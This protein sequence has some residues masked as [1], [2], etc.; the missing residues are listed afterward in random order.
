MQSALGDLASDDK[1]LLTEFF[2]SMRQPASLDPDKEELLNRAMLT[3]AVAAFEA[4]IA[5]IVTAQLHLFPG[6]LDA[7]ERQFS[8]SELEQFE[9]IDDAREAA[10]EARVDTFMRESVE[11]WEKWFDKYA[12]FKV[13]DSALDYDSLREVFERRN[14]VVHNGG[15]VSRQY[16]GRLGIDRA[17][18]VGDPLPVSAEYLERAL[19]ELDVIGIGLSAQVWCAWTEEETQEAVDEVNA[20]AYDL[21]MADRGSACRAVCNI[22]LGLGPT[23]W[24]AEA[25]RVNAWIAQKRADGQASIRDEVSQW[26]T[27]ALAPEFL[28]AK[29]VLLDE[30]DAAIRLAS[31]LLA[32]DGEFTVERLETWP[33][34]EGLR[35]D[36]RYAELISREERPA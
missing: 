18:A 33:L 20:I 32:A 6:I 3:T 8:L 2:A 22:G 13:G 30:N 19:D 9:S 23:G 14:I 11:Y 5:T 24:G 21:L 16:L 34:F 17:P 29:H 28:L 27:S 31:K 25:L 7:S 12:G 35:N 10:I 36:P 26:D 1:R 4:L 15:R